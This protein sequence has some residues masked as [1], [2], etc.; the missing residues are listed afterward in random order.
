MTETP[1]TPVNE[2]EPVSKDEQTTQINHKGK[3][4]LNSPV[5]MMRGEQTVFFKD[6]NGHDCEKKINALFF[7]FNGGS[8]VHMAHYRN[9][10]TWN[11]L[12]WKLNEL[13]EVVDSSEKRTR[14]AIDKIEERTLRRLVKEMIK[15]DV[16]KK[17]RDGINLIKHIISN[18]DDDD[19]DWLY[20]KAY[21]DS[22]ALEKSPWF[23]FM[24]GKKKI[25][26]SEA[27]ANYII[28]RYIEHLSS[29]IL[30]IEDTKDLF[31]Y[32]NGI[33]VESKDDVNIMIRETLGHYS[34]K[35]Y[36][37]ESLESIRM[38]T[39]IKRELFNKPNG[40]LNLNNGIFNYNTQEFRP[41]NVN[42]LFTYAMNIDYDQDATCPNILTYL[43]WAQPDEIMRD[44]ILEEM[45][46][47][48]VSGYP[49][50][51]MFF[52]FGSGGNGKGTVINILVALLGVNNV[53]HVSLQDLEQDKNYSQAGLYGKKLNECGDIPSK[54]TSFDFI[55]AVTGGD[56][57]TVRNI[58]DRPF[59]LDNEAK[60]FFSM[61]EIPESTN[62]SDGPF[63]RLKVTPWY[64][65][66]GENSEP[67]EKE[68]MAS[69]NSP[70][71]L[72]G[73]F[74]VLVKLIPPLL[75]RGDFKY[76]PNADQVRKDL[77]LLK[78]SDVSEFL[79]TKTEI[80]PGWNMPVKALYELY[81]HWCNAGDILPKPL[82]MFL[83]SARQL[84]YDES[85]KGNI[86]VFT[87]LQF[88]G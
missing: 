4:I 1:I 77:A 44:D 50:Q 59:T 24:E 13:D 70:E 10:N 30:A 62:V 81:K 53:S 51:R 60:M 28:T 34:S 19:I 69:L 38:K 35:H 21:A 64:S 31:S 9:E 45:A 7:N 18:L 71:E 39:L 49:I 58:Y 61:N 75:E 46:Y 72:S 52:W 87:G 15:F 67:F 2:C 65:T 63:R 55:D 37:N 26:N 66:K 3:T 33:Y 42:S 73:L 17:P 32:D 85:T 20:K 68:F 22:K 5:T 83:L 47:C 54:K 14:N 86:H 84:K 48:F 25:F 82:K 88:T 23:F 6:S 76:A 78:G 29:N 80:T 43:E 41:H 8:N 27:I 11:T 57:R 74:N 36:V 56:K 40:D 79:L 12:L 16:V